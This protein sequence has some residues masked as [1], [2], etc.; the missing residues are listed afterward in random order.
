MN[1]LKN[2]KL[3]KIIRQIDSTKFKKKTLE[4]MQNDKDFKEFCDDILLTLGYLKNNTF[5]Y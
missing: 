2:E 4:K 1:L 3:K 5:T